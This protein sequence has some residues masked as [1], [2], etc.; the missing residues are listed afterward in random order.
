VKRVAS[1]CNHLRR[2]LGKR[3]R[4]SWSVEK[5]GDDIHPLYQ[6]LT[7]AM[8]LARGN[9]DGFRE[10]LRGYGITPN[11]APEVLWNFE[12]FLIARDGT[13]TARFA[14]PTA[15][16]DHELVAAIEAELAKS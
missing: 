13:V 8:P 3:V 11:P 5:H 2:R 12:K 16:D 15:P 7:T 10:K 6:I 14:P 9:A 1:P 4:E